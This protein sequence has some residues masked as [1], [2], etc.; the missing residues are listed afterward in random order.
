M[1]IAYRGNVVCIEVDV[2]VYSAL[3]ASYEEGINLSL[4][5]YIYIH[6]TY[7]YI[8]IYTHW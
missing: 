4:S 7:I 1:V 3:F 5:L 8:Y 6:N 2:I